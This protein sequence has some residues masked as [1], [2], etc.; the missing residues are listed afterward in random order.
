[1]ILFKYSVN[2]KWPFCMFD[3]SSINFIT[4]ITNQVT[5]WALM[6]KILRKLFQATF[7]PTLPQPL[8]NL[9]KTPL[10]FPFSTDFSSCVKVNFRYVILFL[11]TNDNLFALFF[12]CSCFMCRCSL[13]SFQ[14]SRF[15]LS[16]GCD[17][18]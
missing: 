1:M 13:I 11:S 7:A 9:G 12:Y 2:F 3:V 14:I 18:Q 16:K 8:R 6:D 5:R 4:R 10:P 15:L 17:S